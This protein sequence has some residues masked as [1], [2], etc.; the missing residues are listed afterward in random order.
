VQ[1]SEQCTHELPLGNGLLRQADNRADQSQ[2]TQ[3]RTGLAWPKMQNANYAATLASH[4]E[5]RA[6]LCVA[7]NDSTDLRATAN[8]SSTLSPVTTAIRMQ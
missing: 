1:L 3:L 2:A 4:S 7:I 6:L 5:Y 8:D